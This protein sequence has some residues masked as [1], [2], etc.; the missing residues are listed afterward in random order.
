M[1]SA[2]TTARCPGTTTSQ[3]PNHPDP[4]DSQQ[5]VLDNL[6]LARKLAARYTGRGEDMS[7]L[8]QV[9][10]FGLVLAASRFD[11]QRGTSFASYAIPTILGELKK[12]FRDRCWAVR[13]P[14]PLHDLYHA[15]NAT[16]DRLT[17]EYGRP[18][19]T[20]EVATDLDVSTKELR[21]ALEGG[22]AYSAYSLDAPAGDDP[23]RV[24]ADTIGDDET[25]DSYE[26]IDDRE[27][28]RAVLAQLPRRESRILVLWFFEERTQGEIASELGI[29]QMHVSRL[30]ATTLQQLRA[31]VFDGVPL[32]LPAPRVP[33][34]RKAA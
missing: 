9:A 27:S 2:T 10:R 11:A 4:A 6:N 17:N 33:A 26:F 31:A 30:L 12:H 13:I 29:S 25:Y 16:E 8:V 19:T 7:E 15:A 32:K 1:F 22:K 28:I 3:Q 18:S 24:L 20:E 14:R 23:T 5:L 34:Q 21:E